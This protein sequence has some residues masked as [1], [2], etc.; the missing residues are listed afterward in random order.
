M[1]AETA[2]NI[3]PR[4]AELQRRAEA[5][6][7]HPLDPFPHPERPVWELRYVNRS[8][9]HLFSVFVRN[10]DGTGWRL[11]NVSGVKPTGALL[12]LN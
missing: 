6:L 7:G 2:R 5:E 12:E 9:K 4:V 11:H 1:T 8:G 3:P 10:V